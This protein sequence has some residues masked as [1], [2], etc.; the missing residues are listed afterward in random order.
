MIATNL[1]INFNS[2]TLFFVKI[3]I[4]NQYIRKTPKHICISIQLNIIYFKQKIKKAETSLNVSA[5]MF[6]LSIEINRPKETLKN[7]NY[8]NL[9]K[10]MREFMGYV[11]GITML[12]AELQIKIGL[13]TKKTN[14]R[15]I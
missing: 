11:Q 4:I 14:S 15:G 7:K 2:T 13:G 10:L 1:E 12:V 9:L 8:K 3:K 6:D 5:L